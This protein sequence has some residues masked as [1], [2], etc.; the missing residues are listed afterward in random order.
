EFLH[1]KTA[2][3]AHDSLG[4][5][6][7]GSAPNAPRCWII[8]SALK[9]LVTRRGWGFHLIRGGGSRRPGAVL[10]GRAG[11]RHARFARRWSPVATPRAGKPAA[12]AG[13]E[14]CGTKIRRATAGC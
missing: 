5:F 4:A 6:L 11:R 14:A 12:L 1:A 7:S 8:S 2:I 13:L 9:V 10:A 3:G